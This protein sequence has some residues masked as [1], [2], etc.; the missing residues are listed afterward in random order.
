M[1]ARFSGIVSDSPAHSGPSPPTK[2]G[3][4]ASSTSKRSYDQSVEAEF[5]VRGAVQHR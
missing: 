2:P 4:A 5:L 3:S 1:T